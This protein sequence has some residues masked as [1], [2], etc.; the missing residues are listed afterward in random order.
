M[1]DRKPPPLETY[2]A[3]RTAEM[4]ALPQMACRRRD[5]RRRNEC[6]WHFNANGEPCC[7]NNLN[8][9]QRRAFDELYDQARRIRDH[10][11]WNE[12]LMY[13]SRY[14]IRR[15][16]E[17]AGLDIANTMIHKSDRKRWNAFRRKREALA[18][19]EPD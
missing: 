4:L 17:D 18:P 10:G 14:P 12:R 6:Y 7:L 3:A 8:A 2:L 9:G 5:C 1:S 15:A 11:G 16:L 13:A 19:E